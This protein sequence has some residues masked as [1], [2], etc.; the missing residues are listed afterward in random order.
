[1]WLA[2]FITFQDRKLVGPTGLPVPAGAQIMGV[3]EAEAGT[4]FEYTA[5]QFL[6]ELPPE[7]G[8]KALELS[9]ND[10]NINLRDL[11][12]LRFSVA[13]TDS[14]TV[15]LT[16]RPG[17]V[18]GSTSTA[19][20]ALEILD[21][22]WP[23]GTTIIINVGSSSYV[24]GKGGNG[25]SS[26]GTTTGGAGGTAIYT[27][28]AISIDNGA[29]II[30]GGGGGGGLALVEFSSGVFTSYGGGGGAGR[31]PGAKGTGD[32]DGDGGTLENGGNAVGSGGN[33]GQ[34]G[35]T[36][37]VALAHAGG[38]AGNAIDGVSNVTYI[39]KGDV[40]GPEI[41]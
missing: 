9:A 37:Q 12:D 30:G 26:G 32:F 23:S 13:P 16:I 35:Q 2:D 3:T 6:F 39:N 14:D 15:T 17:V 29:G 27:D 20:P 38:P 25:G 31:N 24:V 36:P 11:Y 5:Q 7:P 19:N 40:R 33:L 10:Y 18:L 4:R 41:N 34:A 22:D 21:A 28:R 1:M 8:D